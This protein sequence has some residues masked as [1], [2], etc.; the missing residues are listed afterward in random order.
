MQ[1]DSDPSVMVGQGQVGILNDG[2]PYGN[3]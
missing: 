3:A 1:A 2:M